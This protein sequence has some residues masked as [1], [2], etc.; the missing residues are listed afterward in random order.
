MGTNCFQTTKPRFPIGR[1]PSEDVV[2]SRSCFRVFRSRQRLAQVLHQLCWSGVQVTCVL[3]LGWCI[4]CPRLPT[5][6]HGTSLTLSKISFFY[7]RVDDRDSDLSVLL[8]LQWRLIFSQVCLKYYKILNDHP[9]LLVF[10]FS[11]LELQLRKI[12]TFWSRCSSFYKFSQCKKIGLS[13]ICVDWFYLLFSL[14]SAR[15]VPRPLSNTFVGLLCS[16]ML[17]P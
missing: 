16:L 7:K 5:F 8:Y 4:T 15:R 17:W 10:A 6:T 9:H 14:H 11:S 3:A 1:K 13:Q 12:V 2:P